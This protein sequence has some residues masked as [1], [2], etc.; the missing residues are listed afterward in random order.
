LRV[1]NF[2]KA[3]LDIFWL[4]DERVEE[5]NCIVYPLHEG[6]T[7]QVVESFEGSENPRA[8]EVLARRSLGWPRSGTTRAMANGQALDR[9]EGSKT[10]KPAT[11][12]SS[13]VKQ[14]KMRS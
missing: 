6:Q 3:N 11:S 1:E 13:A 8:P 5:S 2:D 14:L 7:V 12:N 10:S 9:V 4:R